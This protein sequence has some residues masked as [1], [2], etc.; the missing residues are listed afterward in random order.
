MAFWIP[1]AGSAPV[2]SIGSSHDRTAPSTPLSTIDC[3]NVVLTSQFVLLVLPD[4]PVVLISRS[5]PQRRHD[6]LQHRQLGSRWHAGIVARS[7]LGRRGE[8]AFA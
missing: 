2:P 3:H 5:L 1:T 7:V 6:F 4:M 8:D